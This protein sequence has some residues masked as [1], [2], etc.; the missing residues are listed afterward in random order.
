M[1]LR[2][3]MGFAGHPHVWAIFAIHKDVLE[4]TDSRF[5]KRVRRSKDSLVPAVVA[6]DSWGIYTTVFRLEP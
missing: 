6:A 4:Q 2:K 3:M 5:G 1:E